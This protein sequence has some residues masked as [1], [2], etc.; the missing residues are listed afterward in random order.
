MRLFEHVTDGGAEYYTSKPNDLKTVVCR[1]DGDELEIT[2][3]D[4]LRELGFK[5]VI[6]NG[7]RTEL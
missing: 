5:S 1:T 3:F 2:N 4:K 6:I 7:E